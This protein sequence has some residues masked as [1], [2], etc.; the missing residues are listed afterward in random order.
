M[1]VLGFNKQ[2]NEVIVGEEHE[3][4]KKEILVSNINLL[5][6]DE[7]S[8]WTEVEVK[9]RYSAKQAKAKIIQEKANIKVVFEE[10]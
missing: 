3:L 8:D 2:K 9:T 5:L 1:F 4:Y 6:F 10:P 7:I